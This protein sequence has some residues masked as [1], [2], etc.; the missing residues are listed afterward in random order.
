MPKPLNSNGLRWAEPGN[1][2]RI[3]GLLESTV[4]SS[5]SPCWDSG[6]WLGY[7]SSPRAQFL[8]YLPYSAI[9]SFPV[10]PW[11]HLISH[12]PT[13]GPL[14]LLFPRPGALWSRCHLLSEDFP[15]HSIQ[16]TI[17]R[18]ALLPTLLSL[19]PS[20]SLQVLPVCLAPLPSCE[21]HEGRDC[22]LLFTAESPVPSTE[23]S[24]DWMLKYFLN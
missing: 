19:L 23:S 2:F 16:N 18:S 4:L 15:A 10:V 17:P 6:L 14:Q 3:D 24:T 21:R 22:G 5:C 9:H 11:T 1:A 13:L 7:V 20:H 12:G 8:R